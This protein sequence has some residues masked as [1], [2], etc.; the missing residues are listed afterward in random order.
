MSD[1]E[2]SPFPE[3]SVDTEA[4]RKKKSKSPST[5]SV[6]DTKRIKTEDDLDTDDIAKQYKKF[7]SAPKYN[8]NSEE[9]YCV[10]RRPDNGTLMI[11]CDGCEEWFHTKCMKVDQQHLGLIDKFYCKFCQWKNKGQTRW[12]RKCRSN[13]CF[14]RART[15]NQSKYCSDECGLLFLRLKLLG[16][17][18]FTQKDIHFAINYCATYL[19]LEKLG[20]QFPELDIVL[21]MAIDLFPPEVRKL[22]VENETQ[23]NDLVSEILAV[24]KRRDYLLLIKKRNELVNERAH[25]LIVDFE[26]SDNSKKS[27]KK[28]S[29]PKKTD[30]CCYDERVRQFI[31]STDNDPAFSDLSHQQQTTP[32]HMFK[33]EIDA[34]IKELEKG[35][36]EKSSICLVDRRKCLRHNGWYNLLQDKAWKRQTELQGTLEKLREEKSSI[37]REYSISV[38]EAD[39]SQAPNLLPVVTPLTINANT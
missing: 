12:H 22:V 18:I 15:S 16:S 4:V 37:L 36:L 26:E 7:Q 10:C 35:S 1:L 23:Q 29:K 32:S 13:L 5:F 39:D 30:L 17:R 33:E 11:S 24:S 21:L 20:L 19:S 6:S 31:N 25:V 14:K 27:K 2:A 28:K 8:F 38:Y 3:N 34:A 9:L